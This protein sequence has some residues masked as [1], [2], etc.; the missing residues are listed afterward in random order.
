M[1]QLTL[2]SCGH[3]TWQALPAVHETLPLVPTLTS[4]VASRSQVTLH[5]SAQLPLQ[6]VRA[7]QRIEQLVGPHSTVEKLQVV[8]L[9]QVQLLPPLQ[10]SSLRAAQPS[11]RA[12]AS[13]IPAERIISRA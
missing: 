9:G 8:S 12:S 2:Q 5:E 6:A 10:I 1:S 7:P 11:A 3:V 4:Q 13:V